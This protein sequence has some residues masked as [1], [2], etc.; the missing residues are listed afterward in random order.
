MSAEEYHRAA[1]LSPIIGETVPAGRA[2]SHNEISILLQDCVN[3]SRL[4]G[5]RDAAVIAIMYSGGLRRAEVAKLE[6]YDYDAES[7]KLKVNGKRSKQRSVYLADGAV[8]ALRDWLKVRGSESGPLFVTINK[9]NNLIPEKCLTPQGVYHLLKSRAKRAGVKRFTP[10][11]FRRTF[12][13]DL[14]DAGV[15]IAIVAKM[16]GHAS[17]NTTARYDRRPERA[18]QEAAK[19]LDVPYFALENK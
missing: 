7:H 11:D 16:A 13:G 15:D 12:V 10:H 1:H 17:V 19:L 14:L 8:A 6:L 18:K 9:G 5:A 4:I 2:L 3:D